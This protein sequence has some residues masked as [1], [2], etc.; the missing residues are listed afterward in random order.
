MNTLFNT[1]NEILFCAYINTLGFHLKNNKVFLS[2]SGWFFGINEGNISEEYILKFEK[3]ND[4]WLIH[5]YGNPCDVDKIVKKFAE[6][7]SD[8]YTFEWESND[9]YY[10]PYCFHC[11]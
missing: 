4:K 2:K 11:L 9:P 10:D 5:G 3:E 1:K 8:N 6:I 7:V